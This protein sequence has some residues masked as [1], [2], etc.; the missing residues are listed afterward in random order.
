MTHALD[1]SELL[2]VWESGR[3][4]HPA[5]RALLMLRATC[6]E[7]S[8][9]ALATLSVGQRDASLLAARAA[10]FGERLDGFAGCPCCGERLEFSI[11]ATDLGPQSAP[12]AGGPIVFE[13]GDLRLSVRPPDS[14]D[15]AAIA[16]AGDVEAARQ[17]L[18]RRCVTVEGARDDVADAV[19]LPAAILDRISDLLSAR[20]S[21]ADVRLAMHCV[22]CGHAWQLL[23]DAAVFLWSDIEACADRLLVEVDALA[24]AYGWREADILAMSGTRRRAYLGM[25]T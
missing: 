5:D 18:L 13:D 21:Q 14:R 9:D 3:I 1:A 19:S 22:A 16:T 17:Q 7:L 10:M 20:E 15:L 11:A 12:A 2:S 23:F 4:L 25:V 8:E 24:R 6:P